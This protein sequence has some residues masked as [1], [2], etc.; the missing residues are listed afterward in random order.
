MLV[1]M[2]QWVETQKHMV[3]IVCVCVCVCV[4]VYNSDFLRNNWKVR[5]KSNMQ[6]LSLYYESLFF[7]C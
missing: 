5:K 6:S 3:V 1:T 2:S 7:W 4:C